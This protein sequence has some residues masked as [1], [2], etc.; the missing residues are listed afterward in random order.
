M[1]ICVPYVFPRFDTGSRSIGFVLFLFFSPSSPS[2]AEDDYDDNG[3]CTGAHGDG[4]DGM[5]C[6]ENKLITIGYQFSFSFSS[7]FLLLAYCMYQ[8]DQFQLRY[9]KKEMNG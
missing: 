5:A 7:F 1:S 9:V 8:C 4:I 2:S 6:S 3:F